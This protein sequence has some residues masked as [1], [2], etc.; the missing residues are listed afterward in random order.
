M[1]KRRERDRI[2]FGARR[3]ERRVVEIKAVENLV[4]VVTRRGRRLVGE[5]LRV[6]PFKYQ[7][8]RIRRREL[9]VNPWI[10]KRVILV[11]EDFH[12]GP[13]QPD[14]RFSFRIPKFAK[15]RKLAKC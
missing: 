4:V 15:G 13:P 5:L 10:I 8:R 3:F 1:R 6:G 14:K 2:S 11:A 7:N 9:R 12:R